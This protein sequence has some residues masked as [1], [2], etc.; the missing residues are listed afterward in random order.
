MYEIRGILDFDSETGNEGGYWAIADARFITYVEPDAGVF[1][2][3]EVF[4]PTNLERSGKVLS[5]MRSD[6]T[7]FDSSRPG[8]VTQLV[9]EWEDG[10][11]DFRASS[12]VRLRNYSAEAIHR[13]RTADHLTV[14]E[15]MMPEKVAWC[16]L[17]NLVKHDEENIG[18]TLVHPYRVHH[19][20]AGVD[21]NEWAGWF[22]NEY[23]GL[24]KRP[25]GFTDRSRP[26]EQAPLRTRKRGVL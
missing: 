18:P 13:L 21:Q 19:D 1:E 26:K 23:P 6:G 14:Y 24:L 3:H 20:Q 16:G 5:A 22:L 15:R 10:Q 17:V 9:V 7:K 25:S 4:D 11:Q 12:D 8:D 2:G